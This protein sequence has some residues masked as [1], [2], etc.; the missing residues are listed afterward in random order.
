MISMTFNRRTFLKIASVV[1]MASLGLSFNERK[2]YKPLLAFSSLGCPDWSFKSM[3]DFASAHGY[4]GLEFRGILRELDLSK[5]P[6]FSSPQR[7]RTSR[8]MMAE[9]DL[10]FVNLG[11]SANLHHPEGAERNR[12]MDEAKRFIDL[13]QELS[14]PYVRVFPN[15]F[16]KDQDR[17]QTLELIASGLLELGNYAKGSTVKVLMETHGDIVFTADVETIMKAAAH[18]QVG[19]IWDILNMWTITKEPPGEVY[20]RLKP[21]IA[22]THLKNAT[23]A[24]GKINYVLLNKG[25]VPVFEAIDALVKGGYKGYYSFEWEKLWHPEIEVPEIAL[26]DFPRAMK[27]YFQ[28]N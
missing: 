20:Q 26:A 1:S 15:N 18:P 2:K 19:L 12:Q 8:Q 23:L 5:C 27:E 3:I 6:E 28:N 17:E 22:H 14:C 16:P 11:S 10:K 7:I 24:D 21:Y 4:H 25:E 13:A 9:K